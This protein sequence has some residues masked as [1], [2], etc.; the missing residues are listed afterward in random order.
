MPT[1]TPTV[2]VFRDI[3]R[4]DYVYGS[5]R[6]AE[7]P[8]AISAISYLEKNGWIMSGLNAYLYLKR[9]G[10]ILHECRLIY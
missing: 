7:Y 8:T 10:T 9:D 5:A 2:A 1:N 3:Q 4:G 6:V